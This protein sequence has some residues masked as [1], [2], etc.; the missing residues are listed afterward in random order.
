METEAKLSIPSP[1]SFH[2]LREV[3]SLAGYALSKGESRR[4]FDTYLDTPD[5]RVLQGGYSCRRRVQHNGFCYTLKGLGKAEGS[6]HQREELEL[7][8]DQDMEPAAWPDS[9]ARGRILEIIGSEP[10]TPLFDL[11]QTRLVRPMDREGVHFADMSLDDVRVGIG[12]REQAYFELE[13]ELTSA[14]QV[15]DLEALAA[16]LQSEWGLTPEPRSKFER[17]LALLDESRPASRLLTP[18]ERAICQDVARRGDLYAHRAQALLALDEDRTQVEAGMLAHISERRVRHWLSLFRQKR[19]GVFPSRVLLDAAADVTAPPAVDPPPPPPEPLDAPEPLPLETLLERYQVDRSHA[20]AASELAA[21]LFDYLQ[22]THGLPAS[23]L[24]LLQTAAQIHNVGLEIEPERHHRAGRDILLAH[25]PLELNE[26]ERLMVAMTTFLHNQA[27][28]Q[29]ALDRLRRRQMASLSEKLQRETFILAALVRMADGLDY[30]QAGSRLGEMQAGDAGIVFT[31]VGPDAAADA[32]RAQAKSDL[33][34]LLFERPISFQPAPASIIASIMDDVESPTTTAPGEAVATPPAKPEKP[35]LALDDS[36]AEAARLTLRYHFQIMLYHEPGTRRGED[37]EDLHDMRVAVRRMR[38]ALAVFGDYL[39][40][41]TM[42]PFARG[43]RQTGRLLGAV[44]DLDVFREKAQSYLSGLPAEQASGLT[45][46]MAEIA[47]ER[48]AARA[49][50]LAYLESKRYRRFVEQ[51]GEFLEQPGAGALPVIVED[52]RVIPHRLRH[53]VPITIQQ[54]LA[55]VRSYDQ[56]LAEKEPPL[57]RLHQLRI[58]FKDLRYALEFFREVLGP[59]AGALIEEI[60]QAQDHLGDIQ[61]CVVAGGLLR[62]FLAWG[63][64]QPPA[65]PVEM[66][67]VIAPGAAIYLAARL[68]ELQRLLATFPATW[69][70]FNRMEVRD[71]FSQSLASMW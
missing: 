54:R 59:D 27:I 52:I 44:R 49:E 57:P 31:V 38:M 17:A 35:T 40:P 16:R 12:D 36:M 42:R 21:Q 14:G 56:W 8:L 43:L 67:A 48:E 20:R 34:H 32:Q 60:K 6:I 53:V 33:W 29:K 13:I 28:T 7:L 11:Q 65:K 30:S 70:R 64:F 68:A 41:Q 1:E 45:P 37:I 2:R 15:T 4:I 18:V 55:G 3:A 46:V 25:P 69:E 58:A 10:L 66:T 47:R 50:M 5:R 26:Q 23:R 71:R 63:T 51:F 9:P 61:D 22:P 62:C 39:D 24:A 19:L